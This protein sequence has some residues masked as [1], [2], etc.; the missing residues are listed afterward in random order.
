MTQ[1][2][3]LSTVYVS[4]KFKRPNVN[5]EGRKLQNEN[6]DFSRERTSYFSLDLQAIQPSAVFGPRRKDVLRGA[7]YAWTPVL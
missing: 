3:K 4:H 2:T 5:W 6:G 7:G 1:K